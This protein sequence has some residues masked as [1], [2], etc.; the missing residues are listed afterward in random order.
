MEEGGEEVGCGVGGYVERLGGAVAGG[1]D[2]NRGFRAV[3]SCWCSY[4]SLWVF[5]NCVIVKE[6]RTAIAI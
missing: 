3:Y 4:V 2:S 5:F 6:A 1:M